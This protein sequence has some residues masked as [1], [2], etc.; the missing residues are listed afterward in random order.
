MDVSNASYYIKPTKI[1]KIKVAE[2]GTPK[3]IKNILTSVLGQYMVLASLQMGVKLW[4][5]WGGG[6]KNSGDRKENFWDLSYI[7]QRYQK[8]VASKRSENFQFF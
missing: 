7:G 6:E 1:T 5:L 4:G 8:S 2:W 3:K